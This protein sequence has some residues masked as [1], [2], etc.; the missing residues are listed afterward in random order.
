[1]SSPENPLNEREHSE[2]YRQLEQAIA[3]Q[4]SL[5]GTI[6]DSIID[7]TIATLREKLGALSPLP[8]AEQQRKQITILFADISGFTAMSEKMDAEDVAEIMNAL[9][10]RLD[11]V[12]RDHGG[13]IDKH[14]GDAVMALWGAETAREDDPEQAIRAALAMQSV[15]QET[16]SLQIRIGVNTGPVLLGEVGTT[17]EYTAI[18]DA[19]N[20]ASRLEGAAPLG[21]VLIS[22]DT[23]RHVRGIFDVQS[24]ESLA[25]KGKTDPL[26]ELEATLRSF[27]QQ[28]G[29]KAFQQRTGS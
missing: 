10:G 27:F 29:E 22:H 28:D 15:I 7:A 21:R 11:G 3:A 19:V 1:M 12:I 14:I 16:A 24:R 18:G 6:D 17:D 23:Y 25:V 5:R 13:Y 4:E 8:P 2:E 26:A 9:W 20:V